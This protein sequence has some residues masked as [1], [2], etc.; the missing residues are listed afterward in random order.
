MASPKIDEVLATLYLVT[1]A[2]FRMLAS[3][4]QH[5]CAQPSQTDYNRSADTVHEFTSLSS[6]KQR[7]SARRG[8]GFEEI[9]SSRFPSL[10]F[11]RAR[12][13]QTR[14]AIHTAREP[15]GR[16][17]TAR[18]LPGDREKPLESPSGKE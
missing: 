18:Y 3:R 9:P 4:Q 6:R 12:V 16:G 5:Y 7:G 14:P 8:P 15:F 2:G 11:G 10:H 17:F 1:L 13:P